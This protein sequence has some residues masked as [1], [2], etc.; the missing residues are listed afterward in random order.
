MR[1]CD[2]WAHPRPVPPQEE[3]VRA[4][5]ARTTIELNKAVAELQVRAWEGWGFAK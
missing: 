5:D 1:V 4:A 3:V 2:S